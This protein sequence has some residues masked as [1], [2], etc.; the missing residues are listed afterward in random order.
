MIK[1]PYGPGYCTHRVLVSVTVLGNNLWHIDRHLTR[2]AE[3]LRASM[4]SLAAL[5][6]SSFSTSDSSDKS[7]HWA[8]LVA[9]SSGYGNYRH[10][11]DGVCLPVRRPAPLGLHSAPP[12][13]LL[14]TAV[15]HAYQVLIKGGYAADQIITLAVDDIAH[16][17]ENPFPGKMF[18][19]PTPAG[20]P[21]VDVYAGCQIDYKGKS[22][23]PT[24]FTKVL[25]GD[26]TG[27]GENAKVLRSN[28]QS[29]VFVNFVDHGGVNIIGFPETTMHAKELADAL[30]KMHASK[31]YKEL[32]F[33]L[34]AC[35]SGSMFPD[36][37]P[38]AYATTA[39]NAHESSWGTYCMPQD[40]VDGKSIN[41]CLGDLY[42]V[43][44]MEDA[45]KRTAGETMQGQFELVKART[46]KS[47]VM[48]F[49]SEQSIT[50]EPVT[51]FEGVST[52]P[53][54]PTP[55][56]PTPTPPP[57]PP[58]SPPPSPPP[59]PGMCS[60]APKFLECLLP[61]CSGCPGCKTAEEGGDV[62]ALA[63]EGGAVSLPSEDATLASAFYRYLR[64]GDDAAASE[65]MAGVAE[66]QAAKKRFGAI[67]R[68]VA[69]VG[70]GELPPHAGHDYTCHY[71]AHKAYV[72]RCGEW[73][74]GTTAYSAV[75]AQLCKH[76]AGDAAPITAAIATAC[77]K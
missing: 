76:T 27:L 72:A 17:S 54:S 31:L 6:A 13:Q 75:L 45:D 36:L 4:L 44:W 15:C 62:A 55:P 61:A 7:N 11:A 57:P 3:P 23:T 24:T 22:V 12:A 67:S 18:N 40:K 73:Q 34:E 53:P 47:H 35:E 52:S 71:A 21:G 14:P 28:A 39:A 70:I 29:R 68:A 38:N 9:G 16:N 32:V 56:G 2:E 77:S 26:A 59:C 65:L 20:T 5:S 37:P 63:T 58:P 41:S 8:V 19:K 43:S 60:L 66:R 42:S 69:G 50:A 46:N 1:R 10:Q 51:N 25:T 74:P 33:Y 30:S 64:T 49:V 48:S